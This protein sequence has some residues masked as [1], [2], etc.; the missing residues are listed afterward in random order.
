MVPTDVCSKGIHFY[1]AEQHENYRKEQTLKGIGAGVVGTSLLFVANR[2]TDLSIPLAYQFV[3][4][5]FLT[6]LGVGT[7]IMN[8]NKEDLEHKEAFDFVC[9]EKEDEE[10]ERN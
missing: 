8:Q 9:K 10:D 7:G 5:A 1:L 3:P 2:F 4:L 6:A